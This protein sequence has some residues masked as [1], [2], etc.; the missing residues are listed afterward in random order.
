[1]HKNGFSLSS[2]ILE[3]LLRC[4]EF[5]RVAAK[6]CFTEELVPQS[7]ASMLDSVRN[8]GCNIF[9]KKKTDLIFDPWPL[10]GVISCTMK[11]YFIMDMIKE[12]ATIE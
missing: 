10:D 2:T 7:D 6:H 9:I 1:M 3:T 11:R 8:K 5:F 12:F 4:V